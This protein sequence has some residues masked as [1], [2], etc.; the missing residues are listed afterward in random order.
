MVK[1]AIIRDKQMYWLLYREKKCCVGDRSK[2]DD[3]NVKC[4]CRIPEGT[5]TDI[6]SLL[7]NCVATTGEYVGDGTGRYSMI[8]LSLYCTGR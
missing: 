5:L 8:K 2:V 3:H 1:N 4:S 7:G 6:C